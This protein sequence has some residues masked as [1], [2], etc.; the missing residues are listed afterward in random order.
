MLFILEVDGS[1]LNKIMI[2]GSMSKGIEPV[3]E[4]NVGMGGS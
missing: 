4:V 1:N 2:L 3:I